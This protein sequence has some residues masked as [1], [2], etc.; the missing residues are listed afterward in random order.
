MSRGGRT[1][2]H[3]RNLRRVAQAL[4]LLAFLAAF[5]LAIRDGA[6]IWHEERALEIFFDLDP[7]AAL[8]TLLSTGRIYQGLAWGL[9]TVVLTVVMGRAFCGWFCPMGTLQQYVKYLRR[10][11]RSELLRRN[12]SGSHQYAK[13]SILAFGLA[14]A[15]MGSVFV[16]VLDPIAFLTRGLAEGVVPA[17]VGLMDALTSAVARIPI[18][19]FTRA[20]DGLHIVLSRLDLHVDRTLTTAGLLTLTLF[21]AG[22]LAALWMPRLYCRVVCPLGAALG[23]LSRWSIFGLEQDEQACTHCGRCT[24]VCQ[25]ACDPEPGD[26]RRWLAHECVTCLNCQ[27]ECPDDALRFRFF[28][29]TATEVPDPVD[30]SRRVLLAGAAGGALFVPAARASIQGDP[31]PRPLAIR[32]PGAL[33]ENRFLERCIRCGACIKVCP[34]NVLQPSTT[35]AGLEGLYT[36]VL[37]PMA[38][39]CESTCVAC[40]QVCP[41]GAIAP[42]TSEDKAWE[43]ETPRMKLGQAVINRGRCLPW[44]SR[45]HCIV[46]EEHCP[47]GRKAIV[48]EQVQVTGFDGEPVQLARPVV[49]PELCVGCGTCEHVCPVGSLPAIR[50]L[51][52]NESRSLPYVPGKLSM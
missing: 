21:G 16:G 32:P 43:T 1:I 29:R 11:T 10:W 18:Y 28:P 48:L 37:V 12:R 40:S 46:C 3:V 17:G 15:L 7:L 4:A 38:G 27:A 45:T 41:T 22:L 8:I 34:T 5:F 51:A 31:R 25:G 35:Q 49:D 20:P 42:I 2:L 24:R 39:F 36:P 26:G 6:R 14:A 47:T 30:R 52:V 50:V 13:Y 19:P 44:A 9:V 33:D 23:L